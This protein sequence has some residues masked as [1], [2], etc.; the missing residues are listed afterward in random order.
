MLAGIPAFNEEKN[1]AKVIILAKKHV[2]RVAVC[3]DGSTDMTAEIARE[4]GAEV[5]PHK[6]NMGKGHALRTIFERA[7]EGDV[8]VLVTIDGD[9][10]HDPNQIPNLVRELREQPSDVVIGSRFLGTG[11]AIP[12]HR[13]FGN[14]I[15]NYASNTGVTDS[16]SGF[17]AYSR[18]AINLLRPTEM[19]MGA[20]SEILIEAN[21]S[22]LKITEVPIS[23][24]YGTGRTS[25]TN[26]IQH[27]LDALLTSIKRM[28]MRRPL[29]FYGVPGF[30][31][32][33]I[34]LGLWYW[35]VNNFV[36]TKTLITNVT[37][38]AGIATM[39]GLI[40]LAV[41]VILWVIISVVRER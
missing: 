34:S 12:G 35:T 8:D 1:I 40:L 13:S 25:K 16:Q 39:V 6:K 21:F 32:I 20:D 4:L 26:F 36:A 41:A 38:V 14:K 18:K 2:D 15:L 29:L 31:S 27:G 10:Q 24:V 19:G 37:L 23:V 7:R 28:S 3:D 11:N 22:G 5:L 33:L 30:L 9:G 17:R